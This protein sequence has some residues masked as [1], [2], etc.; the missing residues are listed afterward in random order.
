MKKFIGALAI[1]MVVLACNNS[2]KEPA[3]QNVDT[4]ATSSADSIKNAVDSSM[5]ADSMAKHK[6]S[7][8]AK[9]PIKK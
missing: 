2:G 9:D 1:A 4:S 6:D 8:P 3:T 7:M 5:K